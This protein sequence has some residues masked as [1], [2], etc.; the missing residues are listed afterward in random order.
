MGSRLT[1]FPRAAWAT[2][3]GLGRDAD[4]VL[5]V[6]NGIAFFTTLWRWL[7]KPRVAAR[8]PRPPGALRHRA[9]PRR[10]RRRAAA[11]ARPAALALPAACR[12]SRSRRAR[13]RRS[14][15]SGIARERI[16]VVYLG[17]DAGE[18]RPRERAPDAA[19]LYLG[20]LKRYKRIELLLDVAAAVPD[21][22][23]DIAG[24]GEHRAALEARDRRARPRD[25]VVFHG[26]VDEEE[27]A[28]L[29]GEAWVALTA[30]SAEGWC[31]TVI[32]AGACAHADR[33]AARR[34]PRRGDRRRR[35]PACS[36]T[37][38]D[39]LAEQVG[40]LVDDPE[41]RARARARRRWRGRDGFTW[42]DT[43]RAT[44][45]GDD[46]AA[47]GRARRACA[48][49]LRRSET[50]KAAGLAAATLVNNAHPAG[51][52]GRLHAHARRDRLRHARR[53][54]LRVP[55]PAR[56]RAVGVQLA[57]AREAALDRLGHPRAAARDAARV[58]AAARAGRGRRA[59]VGAAAAAAAGDAHRRARGA[60]GAPR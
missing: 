40:D 57:A 43:A 22:T 53:A 49:P 21:A 5:E 41:R 1:V 18:L 15:R 14:S 44:L 20:R 56:R 46:A 52:H 2:L 24:D 42:D 13:A 38:P 45:D 39:E 16:H 32:E 27:K 51:L 31:L 7:R 34:R 60:V 54:H 12:S 26:H 3:R 58:D 29:L 36:P 19:A 6:V 9:G 8:L 25:R 17:L 47:D 55:D 28:R 11:R 10:P 35:R 4:V 59:R 48:T 33:R 23:L 30:S 50:G 37:R